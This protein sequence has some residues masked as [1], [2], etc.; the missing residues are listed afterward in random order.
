MDIDRSIAQLSAEL[1]TLLEANLAT[2]ASKDRTEQSKILVRGIE[3]VTG[4]ERLKAKGLSTLDALLK[5]QQT[6]TDVE[7]VASLLRGFELGA[8]LSHALH[9]ELLDT[10]GEAKVYRRLLAIFKALDTTSVGQVALAPL[11]DH[12]DVGVRVL[13]AAYLI[14]LMPD[15]VVPMLREIDK[16]AGGR[17]PGFTAH[18][19]LLRWQYDGIM[20]FY[21]YLKNAIVYIPTVVKL[22]TGPHIEVDPVAVVP[23]ANTDALRRALLDAIAR[24]NAI[25]PNPP[26]DGW[27]P[28][29]LLKYAGVKTWSAFARGASQWSIEEKDG[30]YK[31]VGYRTHRDSSWAE[32]DPDQKT[33]FP[34][35]TTVDD[36]VKRMIAI[37]QDAAQK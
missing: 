15:R 5:R 18:F 17:S 8:K 28:P 25:V 26:K 13:A 34:S 29:I 31:I 32:E 27:P 6:A 33:E 35:G 19:A 16:N 12:P 1:D 22:Q 21:T 7:R 10:N 14:D 11:L 23:V 4:L 2:F 36:V 3:I 37:V 20:R 24:K 9:D 30:K